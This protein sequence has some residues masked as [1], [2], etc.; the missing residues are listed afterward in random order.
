MARAEQGHAR[1]TRGGLLMALLVVACALPASAL[2]W[3]KP[4]R[5][6][7]TMSSFPA[8]DRHGTIRT[9]ES[10]RRH[11]VEAGLLGWGRRR[12]RRCGVPGVN[13]RTQF[14]QSA[15]RSNDAGQMLF[16][17]RPGGKH[18]RFRIASAAAG[19]CFGRRVVAQPAVPRK[20]Q[21]LGVSLAP[22]G[23]VM[24]SWAS[25]GQARESFAIGHIGGRLRSRG[26]YG[27]PG[28]N[29]TAAAQFTF[30]R[31]D[32]LVRMWHRSQQVPGPGDRW[33]ETVYGSVSGPHGGRPG[34]LRKL[35]GA[36][37]SGET[38]RDLQYLTDERGGQVA[39]GFSDRGFRLMTR[40]PGHPFGKARLI[41]ASNPF[42]NLVET[43]GNARGDAVFAWETDDT[44]ATYEVYALVR[45]R[46]GKV[47][48]P[49]LISR[50]EDP[51]FAGDPAV[52]IDGQG[53]AIVAYVAQDAERSQL[54]RN[55]IR[56][57]V[58]GRRGGFG[59]AR[60]ITG[61]PQTINRDPEVVVNARG[62][63]AVW[64]G[65]EVELPDGNLAS[66][67]LLTRG[68]LGR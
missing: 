49:T 53:R 46:N 66:H 60:S 59:P 20:T 27:D 29:L 2:G 14:V 33:R 64:F 65:R 19:R 4:L 32:R 47:E 54:V 50:G 22:L 45:R 3:D 13:Q 24:A 17:W 52:G 63:A 23:T 42:G 10:S 16:G 12:S 48:G 25:Y 28:P 5:L 68:R 61:P 21:F 9:L 44:T 15:W 1:L 35:A 36:V 40:R 34:K 7:D 26:H 51:K 55:Q 6:P 30:I 43:A 31:G 38:L 11:R 18:A 67:N 56:V 41:R 37:G 57:A 58:C 8:I 62:Q 39:G